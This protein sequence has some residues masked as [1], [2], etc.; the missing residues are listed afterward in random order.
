VKPIVP[1]KANRSSK[2]PSF[3]FLID[4]LIAGSLVFAACLCIIILAVWVARL[5]AIDSAQDRAK[6]IASSAAQAVTE[7]MQ[8]APTS[9]LHSATHEESRLFKCIDKAIAGQPNVI[10]VRRFAF[11]GDV[12]IEV[13]DP[14]LEKKH[15]ALSLEDDVIDRMLAGVQFVTHRGES[16]FSAP[17]EVTAYAPVYE[18]GG[19]MHGAVAVDLEPIVLGAQLTLLKLGALA[20]AVIAAV[21]A[22]LIALRV[23]SSKQRAARTA[24]QLEEARQFDKLTIQ[25]LGEMLYTMDINSGQIRW[26]VTAEGR[27]GNIQFVPPNT[28]E[29][30]TE[31]I[32]PDDRTAFTEMLRARSTEGDKHSLE[33]RLF[34]PTLGNPMVWVIDRSTLTADAAGNLVSVGAIVDISLRKSSDSQLREFIDQT[35]TAQFVIDGDLIVSANPA[36]VQM[37]AAPSSSELSKRSIWSLWPSLQPDGDISAAAWS[38]HVVAAIEGGTQH[39]EWLFCRLDGQMLFVDVFLKVAILESRQVILMSCHDLTKSKHTQSLLE[40]SERRFRDVTEAVGEFVW[41]VDVAGHYTYASPRVIDILGVAPE[42]AIGHN[43][44]EWTD[45]EDR[46]FV[47]KRSAEI[48]ATEK[49]FRDFVHRV[50]RS[51]GVLRWIRVSGVPR[52]DTAGTLMGYRGIT[53]DI[54]QQREYEN[55]L[56]LQKEAAETA[57][58]AKSSFLAMMSHEIRTPLNSVLGF[59]EILLD[60]PLTTSQRESLETIR[61]SGD[62]LLHLLNDILDFSKIESNTVEIDLR[63]TNVRHCL[64]DAIELQ[65]PAAEAK[66]L[67]IDSEVDA[68]VPDWI[69]SD[70]V[71]LKQI[72]LNLIANAV[73]FTAEGKVTIRIATTPNPD[74]TGDTETQYLTIRIEDSG[75]GIRPEQLERLFKPFSQADSSINRQFGGTG[76]GLVIS[77]RLARLMG[78]DLILETTSERGTVFVAMFPLVPAESPTSGDTSPKSISFPFPGPRILV[79]DD[80]PINR[81]LTHR[82]LGQFGAR[83][84]TAQSGQESIE[85]LSEQTFDAILM[86][87]QMPGMDGHE[88]TRR[89]R[90]MEIEQ[91]RQRIPIIA[92]TAGAM[93]GDR[94]LCLEAGMD[95]YLT[96]PIRREAL[97]AAL[98]AILPG[99]IRR[100]AAEQ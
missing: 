34:I 36:A 18:Q 48:S 94:E 95:E 98:S 9:P 3:G 47:L 59:T 56:L 71:R 65:R 26:R 13:P 76:L 85:I 64:S 87:V 11:V 6:R 78:G 68:N 74:S 20:T 21:F 99:Q 55:E 58:R 40:E 73:K 77:R 2:S 1:S 39:F 4:A 37:V 62:A 72:L 44:L 63:P 5:T 88:A 16:W 96:K 50:R 30:W 12:P 46:E 70:S 83:V 60:S 7:G 82:I 32:H 24:K 29:A 49:Q 67:E 97:I 51:D 15:E 100:V 86:D 66:Q 8:T 45:E 61:S 53:L 28:I 80:N 69:A 90:S 14:R 54:T 22:F 27:F 33:Y 92:L 10:R 19:D 93:R 41:E 57:D 31:C 91:G 52:F 23:M 38:R 43:P 84:E 35:P 42:N 89:I 81:R 25:A 75:I 17:E 79:V